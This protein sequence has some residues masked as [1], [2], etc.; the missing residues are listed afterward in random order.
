MEV[1]RVT[2]NWQRAAVY[3]LRIQVFVEG[4]SI[5]L[6]MEFDA[7]DG[8][9]TR[10]VLIMEDH[11]PI[12]TARLYT[13][14]DGAARIGRVGVAAGS[15]GLGVGRR[16][17]EEAEAWARELGIRRII[18][19]SQKHAVGFYERLGYSVNPDIVFQ[20]RIPIVHTEKNL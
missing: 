15:R 5:P 2:E 9:G 19:T 8:D 17:I 13:D 14:D 12:A 10:Y 18:I 20:S 4:Q 3:W 6:E 1:I 11:R 7:R 16:V